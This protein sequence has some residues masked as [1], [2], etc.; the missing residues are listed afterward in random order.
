M[1]RS[2]A[3]ILLI[4]ATVF[5]YS[6]AFTPFE[7]TTD[8]YRSNDDGGLTRVKI[9]CPSPVSVL[10]FDDDTESGRDAGSCELP[11]RGHLIESVLVFGVGLLLAW[12]PITRARPTSIGPLSDKLDV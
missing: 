9:E 4:A 5:A 6:L 12:K 2:A 7:H 11:A 10:F 1:P 3:W 8:R